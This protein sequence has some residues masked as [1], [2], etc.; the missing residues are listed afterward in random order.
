MGFVISERAGGLQPERMERY[1]DIRRRL[2]KLSHT[3][4]TMAQYEELDQLDADVLVLSGSYDPWSEHDPEALEQLG[5]QL[6]SFDGPV[7]G[8][9]A[10][11]QVLVRAA[12]GVVATA[13]KPTPAGFAAVDVLDDSDLLRGL[14]R[15]GDLYE[16]HTDEVTELPPGF[17]VLASSAACRVEAVAA[18]DRRW[19]GTQFHPERWDGDHPAGRR[20]IENFLRLA[21]ITPP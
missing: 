20:V 5:Q 8:I 7:L 21:G 2:S 11:M 15:Q 12:G 9:C 10:G 1:R 17:R 16:H 18:T 19:W 3:A 14:D 4:V 6:R 13:P